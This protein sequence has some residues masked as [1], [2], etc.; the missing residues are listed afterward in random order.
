MSLV[1]G[2]ILYNNTFF[3]SKIFLAS[4]LFLHTSFSVSLNKQNSSKWK[5]ELASSYRLKFNLISNKL[6]VPFHRKWTILLFALQGLSRLEEES[7][8][9]G[10]NFDQKVI[11]ENKVDT[12]ERTEEPPHGLQKRKGLMMLRWIR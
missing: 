12:H 2:G 9:L 1:R 11:E 3:F 8:H 5:F 7:Q 6:C 4:L 10:R